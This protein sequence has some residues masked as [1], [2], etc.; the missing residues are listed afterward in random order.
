M[1]T[2]GK[3]IRFI[4]E[5][6]SWNQSEL[7]NKLGLESAVA[8]SKYESDQREPDISKL[9]K[10]S[11]LGE[12]DLNWLLTGKGEMKREGEEK[13]EIT[14]AR[15]SIKVESEQFNKEATLM[16]LIEK[17]KLIYAKGGRDLKAWVRGTI[18]EACNEVKMKEAQKKE[19]LIE[20]KKVG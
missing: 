19:E 14:E 13:K 11:E 16:V 20:Q 15:E 5:K 8:I 18:D 10:L 3:R 6:K 12:V 2:L 4:R 9:I 17:L 7:A 1:D